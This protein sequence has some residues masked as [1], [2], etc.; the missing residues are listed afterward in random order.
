VADSISFSG[1][2]SPFYKFAADRSVRMDRAALWGLRQ[3]ARAGTKAAR[4]AA[5]TLTGTGAMTHSQIQRGRRVGII[6]AED[7]SAI[8]KS[9]PV[10]GLLRA[11]IRTSK[12]A[13]MVGPHA[14]SL[15]FGP[16]GERVH[17]YAAKAER[18]T[19]FMERGRSAAE[20]ALQVDAVQ[21]FQK[22]W[23]A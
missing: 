8:Y 14:Y 11:S 20:A 19:P 4:T 22:V 1:F 7:A 6:S 16:R 5:P 3:A 18:R 12:H 15:T 9:G 2:F 21:A 23:K 13:R 17:L 10:P